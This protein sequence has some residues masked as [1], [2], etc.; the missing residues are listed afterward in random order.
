MRAKPVQAVYGPG[1]FLNQAVATVNTRVRAMV[2][3]V[4]Q[5]IRQS[6][7]AAYELAIGRHMTRSQALTAAKAAGQL[8]QQQSLQQL[9]QLYLDSGIAGTPRIDDP[10]FIP[11]I[12]FDTTRGVNQPKARFAYLFPTA[13]SALIQVRLKGSL[14]DAQQ[15][16]AISWIRQAVNMPRFRS[17]YGASYTVTGEPVVVNDLAS[18]I[19]GSI[20]GLLI[21]AMVVMA[22]TLMIVFPSRPRRLRLLPLAIALAATGITFGALSLIGGTL[23]MASIAVLPILI[24]LAVDYAIQ[25]QSRVA[26]ASAQSSAEH[27]VLEA[28]ATGAPTIAIAALATATGF[29][30]LLLSPVP[31]VQGFGLLLVVGIAIALVC[32]LTAGSAAI[33]LSARGGGALAASLR[34]AGEILRDA[35]ARIRS[36]VGGVVRLPVARVPPVRRGACRRSCPRRSVCSSARWRGPDASW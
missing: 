1:T 14:S 3:G 27:A 17:A 20:L 12:V 2:A 18:Q 10:Q 7:Q 34:G 15:A 26:E 32:A 13:D 16:Q 33:V 19:T 35:G 5:S 23:T 28:A 24:G 4:Q 30:V 9:E 6:E 22:A 11:Q 31:M 25:F 36:R 8:Q 21:G 29:L